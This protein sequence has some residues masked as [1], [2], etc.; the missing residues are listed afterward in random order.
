MGRAG[1]SPSV[2]PLFHHAQQRAAIVNGR[3]IEACSDGSECLVVWVS[4][5]D[6]SAGD[7]PILTYRIPAVGGAHA[8]Y[9][10]LY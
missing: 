9:T 8:T 10:N 4:A 2:A 1:D 3:S 5:N 6:L 7:G